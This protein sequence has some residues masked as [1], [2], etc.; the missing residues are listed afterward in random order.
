ME[1]VHKTLA[2]VDTVIVLKQSALM[3][4][5]PAELSAFP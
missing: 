2:A 3:I 5:L 4:E 1:I